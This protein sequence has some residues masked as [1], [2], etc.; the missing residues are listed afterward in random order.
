MGGT[1]KKGTGS[2]TCTRAK[3]VKNMGR[4]DARVETRDSD[5]K[6]TS[7]E[8]TGGGSSDKQCVL[9]VKKKVTGERETEE[10][11]KNHLTVM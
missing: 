10:H 3:S 2:T 9:K 5:G 4:L 11:R 7:E 8:Q 6:P 1:P